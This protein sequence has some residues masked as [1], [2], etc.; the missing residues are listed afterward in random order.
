M[1]D[2]LYGEWTTLPPVDLLGSIALA[3]GVGWASGLRLY[4][5]ILLLG[6]VERFHWLSLPRGASV[7]AQPT[8]LVVAAVL[9]SIE[10]IAD[11]VP[12]FDSTWDK[13]HGFVRAPGGAFLAAAVVSGEGDLMLTV[14]AASIGFALATGTHVAKAT[15][16]SAINVSPKSNANVIVSSVEEA[17]VLAG[18]ALLL[19]QPVAFL[20]LLA[21]FLG[22]SCIAVFRLW[23]RADEG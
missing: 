5:V 13:V 12:K 6:L 21:F 10:F 2:T 11:K 22:A 3:V 20:V 9:S 7:F 18:F 1:T 15:L 8:L 16:R 23:R 17:L 19:V 4:L 14:T